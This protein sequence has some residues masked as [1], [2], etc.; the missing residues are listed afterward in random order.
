MPLWFCKLASS[1]AAH[2]IYIMTK[3]ICEFLYLPSISSS[4]SCPYLRWTVA[5]RLNT[6]K[7]WYR[8][9]KRARSTFHIFCTQTSQVRGDL[10]RL[11][12]PAVHLPPYII[13]YGRARSPRAINLNVFVALHSPV[14]SLP[15]TATAVTHAPPPTHKRAKYLRG[16]LYIYLHSAKC[17]CLLKFYDGKCI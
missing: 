7:W 13:R 2:R 17:L 5:E 12:N 11:Q 3:F 8:E 4:S 9:S 15:C 16:F 6:Q 10:W 14:Q 1:H